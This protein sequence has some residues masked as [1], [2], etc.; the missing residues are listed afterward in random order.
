MK[1]DDEDLAYWDEMSCT[2]RLLSLLKMEKSC[3]AFLSSKPKGYLVLAS[4][5]MISGGFSNLFAK[6][7]LQDSHNG[8]F[9]LWLLLQI[10]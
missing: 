8:I 2:G 7:M 4:S 10:Q 1:L 3:E 6:Q 9:V 5:G